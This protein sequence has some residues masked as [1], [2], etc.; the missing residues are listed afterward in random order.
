MDYRPPR[1][2]SSA[3]VLPRAAP[4]PSA[5]PPSA[6]LALASGPYGF[7]VPQGWSEQRLTSG[8]PASFAHFT[9]LPT[10]RDQVSGGEQGVVYNPDHSANVTGAL[11]EVGCG[12]NTSTKVTDS[13][14][15]YTCGSSETDGA[16]I[17]EAFPQGWKT[18]Q[19]TLR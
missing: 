5:P 11:T 15:S 1:L 18:L 2:S 4:P 19:V 6:P 13:E 8:G 3:H 9:D 12:V 16:V 17:V 14:A 10:G 7:L